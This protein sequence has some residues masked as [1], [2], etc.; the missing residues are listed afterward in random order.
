MRRMLIKPDK[1]GKFIKNQDKT[2]KQA[3]TYY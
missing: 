1:T 3:K 2:L